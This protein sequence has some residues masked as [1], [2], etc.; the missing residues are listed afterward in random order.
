MAMTLAD[1]E[2]EY[3]A[4]WGRMKSALDRAEWLSSFADRR[5]IAPI[6][7]L[8]FFDWWDRRA[9]EDDLRLLNDLGWSPSGDV[10]ES[11]QN[12]TQAALL[13]IEMWGRDDMSRDDCVLHR[14]SPDRPDYATEDL[15]IYDDGPKYLVYDPWLSQDRGVFHSREDAELFAEALRRAKAGGN[16]DE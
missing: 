12:S 3:L 9:L 5:S 1:Y 14:G 13:T 7:V 6:N 15:T 10:W 11:L 2:A 4:E 8:Q 16:W